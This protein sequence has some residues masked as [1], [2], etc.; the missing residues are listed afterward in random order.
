MSDEWRH[1][2]LCNSGKFPLAAVHRHTEK[3]SN[4]AKC[5]LESRAEW[6]KAE[7]LSAC[8]DESHDQTKTRAFV[9]A[10]LLGNDKDWESF[11]QHWKERIGDFIFHA[12]D[13][14]SGHED[15]KR[16]PEPE[17]LK[18]HLDLTQILADMLE[19]FTLT[20]FHA[21]TRKCTPSL[22]WTSRIESQ[23]IVFQGVM[24]S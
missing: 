17:R 16:M 14:E 3:G 2:Q 7:M 18:L 1:E 5:L 8:G 6:S 10:G 11:R 12:A 23:A 21:T 22:I 24:L 20:G 9:V 19:D 13:C 4:L 15:F